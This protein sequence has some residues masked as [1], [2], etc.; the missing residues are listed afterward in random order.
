MFDYITREKCAVTGEV[1]FEPL[2]SLDFP[3]FCGC[4]N[5]VQDSDIIAKMDFVI[6]KPSGVLQLKTLSHYQCCM[7]TDTMRVLWVLC[8]I[9][10]TRS[11]R[12][13]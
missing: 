11:L 7:K 9:C 8:G 4:T 6:S 2:F 12:I 5:E 13:L 3:L 1:E 10:I